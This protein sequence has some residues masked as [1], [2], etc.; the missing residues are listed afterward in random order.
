MERGRGG[1]TAAEEM[2]VSVTKGQQRK[3]AAAAEKVAA[4]SVQS[5]TGGEEA[6]ATGT[7][8]R[9]VLV[10]GAAVKEEL[11]MARRVLVAEAVT[12]A[13]EVVAE[14]ATEGSR[15]SGT[16]EERVEATIVRAARESGAEAESM[17]VQRA[18]EIVVVESMQVGGMEAARGG[19]AG[20]V[21][22][23]G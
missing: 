5:A 17:A 22:A 14:A 23:K 2:V 6:A 15:A 1:V 7:M 11:D 9:R 8:T 19:I 3:T 12:A 10:A 20:A 4:R 16:P 21:Q 18:A 13:V